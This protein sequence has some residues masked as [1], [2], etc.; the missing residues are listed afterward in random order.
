MKVPWIIPRLGAQPPLV[1]GTSVFGPTPVQ[2]LCDCVPRALQ[3]CLPCPLWPGTQPQ[4]NIQIGKDLEFHLLSLQ[5]RKW[6]SRQGKR[7]EQV[8]EVGLEFRSGTFPEALPVFF[9]IK[10]H[11]SLLALFHPLSSPLVFLVSFLHSPLHPLL[12]PSPPPPPFPSSPLL[13]NLYLDWPSLKFQPSALWVQEL[14]R[15]DKEPLAFFSAH[16]PQ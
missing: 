16:L 2:I 3:A 14:S 8:W 11:F 10:S 9:L 4:G 1:A 7:L 6:E 5:R 15:L 12:L 13:S